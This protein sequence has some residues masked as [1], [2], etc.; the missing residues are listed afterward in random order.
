MPFG[1]PPNASKVY[2]SYTGLCVEG[3]RFAL[4]QRETSQEHHHFAG[5]NPFFETY[6]NKRA[7]DTGCQG[8]A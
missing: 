4:A 5:P 1:C 7:T 2:E 8:I 3:T 6:Q